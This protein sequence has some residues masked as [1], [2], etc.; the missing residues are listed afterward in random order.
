MDSAVRYGDFP[1]KS[2]DIKDT[3]THIHAYINTYT[4]L[5]YSGRESTL[6]QMKQITCFSNCV[7]IFARQ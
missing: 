1:S 3:Y 2:S 5:S 6:K 7:F 4:F